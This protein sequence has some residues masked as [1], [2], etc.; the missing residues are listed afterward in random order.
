MIHLPEPFYSIAL[1]QLTSIGGRE[2]ALREI[3]KPSVVE[4]IERIAADV[5]NQAILDADPMTQGNVATPAF[6][7]PKPLPVWA[8]PPATRTSLAALK[9]CQTP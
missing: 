2:W 8:K 1:A 3:E 7:E 9:T 6:W 5:F 4:K